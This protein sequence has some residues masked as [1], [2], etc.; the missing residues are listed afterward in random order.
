MIIYRLRKRHYTQNEGERRMAFLLEIP[1]FPL[2][3]SWCQTILY[4]S[5]WQIV[6]RMSVAE[7][8]FQKKI[9]PNTPGRD[10]RSL[11]FLDGNCSIGIQ[12]FET[13]SKRSAV[14]PRS[15]RGH[16]QS[17]EIWSRLFV[18]FM[19]NL[20]RSTSLSFSGPQTQFRPSMDSGRTETG[21]T[22]SDWDRKWRLARLDPLVL[23]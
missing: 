9:F 13:R 16:R 19:G 7:S 11:N 8:L 17:L 10:R 22:I 4:S 14:W 5:S 12:T 2:L 1:E 3:G 20:T 6:L 15:S 18:N 23:R 21:E